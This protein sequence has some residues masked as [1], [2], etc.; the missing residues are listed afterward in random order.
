MCEHSRR[1]D[2]GIASPGVTRELEARSEG[3]IGIGEV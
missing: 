3:V 2:S 1:C